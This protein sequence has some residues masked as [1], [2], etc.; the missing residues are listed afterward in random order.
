MSYLPSEVY[1]RIATIASL[2]GLCTRLRLR[3]RLQQ[4]FDELV[5]FETNVSQLSLH[6]RLQ[7]L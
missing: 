6:R 3:L 2:C 5:H 1:I 4:R 7:P